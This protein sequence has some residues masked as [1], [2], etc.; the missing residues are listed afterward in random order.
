[1]RVGRSELRARRPCR[2]GCYAVGQAHGSILAVIMTGTEQAGFYGHLDLDRRR[3]S[4]A[5]LGQVENR[6]I[7]VHSRQ[8]HEV[9]KDLGYPECSERAFPLRL[10]ELLD[11]GGGRFI[12]EQSE[13]GKRVENDHFRRSWSPSS[14]L[15]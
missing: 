10:Y 7:V 15:D 6:L 9:I 4:K 3:R 11:V 14:I 13:D 8:T 12:F 5:E 2:L 1:M